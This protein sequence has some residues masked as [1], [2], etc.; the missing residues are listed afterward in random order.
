MIFRFL[1]WVQAEV[2]VCTEMAGSGPPNSPA[3]V[4]SAYPPPVFSKGI[5]RDAREVKLAS[6]F[7]ELLGEVVR[8]ARDAFA[9]RGLCSGLL[10]CEQASYLDS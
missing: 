2:G 6:Q 4:D 5:V 7:G 10:T 1:L 3:A 9:D 8:R